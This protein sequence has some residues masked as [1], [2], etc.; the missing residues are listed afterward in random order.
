MWDGILVCLV[1]YSGV[2]FSPYST[3]SC[4]ILVRRRMQSSSSGQ[5]VERLTLDQQV[6]GSNPCPKDHRDVVRG[7]AFSP[8][9]HQL[10][11]VSSDNTIRIYIDDFPQA[12]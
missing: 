9:G 5:L 2:P 10:T 7:I 6:Q 4:K 11:T 3:L 12:P 1:W 8:D